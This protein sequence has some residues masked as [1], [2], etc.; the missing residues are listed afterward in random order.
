[1]VSGASAAAGA[2]DH[3]AMLALVRLVP[4]RHR[5]IADMT[6]EA[7]RPTDGV[8]RKVGGC[9]EGL[10]AAAGCACLCVERGR[11]FSREYRLGGNGQRRRSG[12]WGRVEV[13]L[14]EGARIRD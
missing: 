3:L 4:V 7:S 14:V 6:R 11:C 8:S 10:T 12:C 1:M 13:Q 9:R 2:K 5:M